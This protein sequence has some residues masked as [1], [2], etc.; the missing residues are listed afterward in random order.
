MQ[1]QTLFFIQTAKLVKVDSHHSHTV[2]K[3]CIQQ[4][5]NIMLAWDVK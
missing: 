1:T 3:L 4:R 2:L 5:S